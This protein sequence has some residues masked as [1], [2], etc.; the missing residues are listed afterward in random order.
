MKPWPAL[1]GMGKTLAFREGKLFFFDSGEAGADKARPALIL[2][3]GLGDEADSWRH[4]LPL[5]ASAGY[6]VIA[7]DLPGFGRSNSGEGA[8]WKG[9]ISVGGHARALITLMRETGAANPQ[10]PAV[11]V[12][13][14]M[15]AGI[16]QVVASRCPGLAQALV[17]LDGCH[18][19]PGGVDRKLFVMGLPFIG[20]KWYRG[21]RKN[22]EAARKSLFSYYRDFNAM[23]EDDKNFL[24]R[25]VVDRVE[26]V[27]QE[28]AYFASLRSINALSVFAGARFARDIKKFPGKILLAWG[29][30]DKIIPP[31][32]TAAFR[33]IRPDA[34][35]TLIP[36]AGHLP[37]Q[38]APEQTA[39]AITRFLEQ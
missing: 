16:A 18:P 31:E 6:R 15:G 24:A 3:H 34:D 17:L 11:L 9:R 1:A 28:R 19:L 12:G 8:P 27:S 14:S 5:L 29:E 2:I 20:K 4:L 26:S 10:K 25:R 36:G 32:K 21:F 22:H 13:S 37:Q 38:D 35:F 33:A 30:A 39:L 7:P 23:S